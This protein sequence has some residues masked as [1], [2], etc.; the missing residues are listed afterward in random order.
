MQS[1]MKRNIILS[2]AFFETSH[3]WTFLLVSPQVL[4]PDVSFL[5]DVTCKWPFTR[6]QSLVKCHVVLPGIALLA[7]V[8]CKGPF[9]K[10]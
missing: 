6:V 9:T 5:A 10:V 4:S 2:E 1:L 3:T 8:T 7:E